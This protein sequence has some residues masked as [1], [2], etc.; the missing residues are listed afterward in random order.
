M[1]DYVMRNDET[2]DILSNFVDTLSHAQRI[3]LRI[4]LEYH[5]IPTL[6]NLY[7]DYG[8][9]EWIKLPSIDKKK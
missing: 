1:Y 6:R 5:N 2:E 7:Y 4:E 8:R 3:E 9:Q